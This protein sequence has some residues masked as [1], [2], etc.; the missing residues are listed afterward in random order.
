[1]AES[2]DSNDA[3]KRFLEE[4]EKVVSETIRPDLL[5]LKNTILQTEQR[6]SN[7]KDHSWSKLASDAL[8]WSSVIGIVYIVFK[9]SNIS[10]MI[11]TGGKS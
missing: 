11:N 10:V 3:K 9:P 2:A 7:Q 8:W 4:V 1:M 5:D 6:L